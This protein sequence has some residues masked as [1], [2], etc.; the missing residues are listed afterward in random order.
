MKPHKVKKIQESNRLYH[1]LRN[2]VDRSLR[3]A[4]RDIEYYGR[5][6]LPK[7]AAIIYA[8]NHSNA[9]M[10]ALI[11]LTIDKQQK[12]FVARADIFKN[13]V[14]AKLLNFFKIMPIMRIRDGVEEV[15]KNQEII[16][17]SVDV[18][19]DG[20]PFCILPEGTHRAQHSLLP[21]SKGIFRI[22]LQSQQL[23]QDK[24]D[25][26]I[27]P[28]GIE[29]GNYFRYHSNVHIQLGTPINIRQFQENHP[30]L[31]PAELINE[32]R[33]HLTQAMRQHILY[34]P[35]DDKYQASYELTA[36]VAEATQK[37]L[38]AEN[39]SLSPTRLRFLANQKTAARI[40]TLRASQ[41][42]AMD[43]LLD[44]CQRIHE[45]R[46]RQKI[47]LA[48]MVPACPWRKRGINYLL[49]L[50]TF[51][52]LAGCMLAVSPIV[53]IGEALFKYVMKDKAFHNSVRFVLH[54]V[55]WPLLLVIY[56]SI[57]FCNL[58]WVWALLTLTAVLP[59]PIFAQDCYQNIRLFLS[60]CKWSR[61]ASLRRMIRQ[62]R[63]AYSD[64][65]HI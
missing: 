16:D 4:Y 19:L 49:S 61:N 57:L 28:V 56:G 15:K 14:I 9:L 64:L 65:L 42:E 59:A 50:I 55:L 35:D 38:R 5:E 44:N 48:S 46:I 33:T 43:A 10:D 52:Y 17:K 27:V 20:V 51:P 25:V 34:L 21:L 37:E 58:P 40:A 60:D 54:L 41:P 62:V 22:A 29:Y 53:G 6:Q 18:L 23:L 1:F 24:K 12:V 11:V 63:S 36:L 30:E 7:D 39:P 2:Y 31:Q 47:S 13:P 3:Q 45:E 26:C 32:L 8:P